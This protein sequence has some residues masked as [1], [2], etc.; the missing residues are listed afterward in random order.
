LPHNDEGFGL[1]FGGTSHR[2]ILQSKF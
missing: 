1:G 2:S